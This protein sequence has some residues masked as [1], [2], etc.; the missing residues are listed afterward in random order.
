MSSKDDR[1][2]NWLATQRHVSKV[3]EHYEALL[4][5]TRIWYFILGCVLGAFAL[6]LGTH[7]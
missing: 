3:V 5:N 7:S 4:M 2:N 6:Y 1:W